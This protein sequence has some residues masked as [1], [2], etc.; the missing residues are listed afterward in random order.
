MNTSL[1]ATPGRAPKHVRAV[2]L[3]AT[4]GLALMGASVT[5][6]AA[7]AAPTAEIGG[8]LLEG[9][10]PVANALVT[11]YTLDGDA[12]EFEAEAR[13]D[14]AGEWELVNL[15]DGDYTLEFSTDYSS[16]QYALGETLSGAADLTDE[17]T[18]FVIDDGQ[19]AE[20]PFEEVTLTRLGGAIEVQIVDEAGEPFIDLDD[21]ASEVR[22]LSADGEEWNS[23]TF[24]ADEEGRLV[25]PR[26]P[27]GGYVPWIGVSGDELAPTATGVVV[28]A[29]TTTDAG[30]F[31]IPEIAE[32]EFDVSGDFAIDGEGTVGETLKVHWPTTDP[33]P[34]STQVTWAQAGEVL[35]H[36][37]PEYLATEDDVDGELTAWGFIF[38]DGFTPVIATDSIEIT[39]GSDGGG[40]G[41]SDEDGSGDEGSGGDGSG[42]DGAGD[43]GGDGDSD[44]DDDLAWTGVSVALLVAAM[45]G[46]LAVGGFAYRAARTR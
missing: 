31:E 9:D 24:W 19:A 39:A 11:A 25:V 3:A 43:T 5:A 46:L 12:H 26:I 8:T 15:P 2:A 33:E 23:R 21:A 27:L 13:T 35:A 40:G 42:D 28:E 34:G 17:P 7:S 30:T 10:E 41:G 22:G 14:E 29:E 38:A 1:T 37:E 4:F 44:S 36:D 45:L 18:G 20:T 6:G 32:S 16:A